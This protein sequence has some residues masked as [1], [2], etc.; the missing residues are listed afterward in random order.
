MKKIIKNPERV[1]IG[2][3]FMISASRASFGQN[4]AFLLIWA[5]WGQQSGISGH[6]GEYLA[7]FYY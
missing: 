5:F 6:F 1:L 3:F 7:L 2:L 4:L